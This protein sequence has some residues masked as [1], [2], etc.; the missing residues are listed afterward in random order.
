MV[1]RPFKAEKGV[2]FFL[3]FGFIYLIKQIIYIKQIES[4]SCEEAISYCF[5]A[6]LCLIMIIYIA[7]RFIM[8]TII[9]II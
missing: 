9:N 6:F 2:A 5:F 3:F 7:F 1:S 8:D 4:R